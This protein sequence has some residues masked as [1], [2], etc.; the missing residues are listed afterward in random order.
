V[1]TLFSI[2]APGVLGNDT[3]ADGD[4]LTAILNVGPPNGTL[5]LNPN[6]SFTY[7]PNANFTGLDTFTYHAN[8]GTAD[9]NIATVTITVYPRQ[10]P[11][12]ANGAIP[13]VNS[14]LLD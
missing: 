10:D 12:V 9:S 4:P 7:T 5:S 11:P 3:D 14:L 1:E 2:A 6:G 8:D 13:A